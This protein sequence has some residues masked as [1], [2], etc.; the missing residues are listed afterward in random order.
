MAGGLPSLVSAL[1]LT[2]PGDLSPAPSRPCPIPVP[3]RRCPVSALALPL[4]PRLLLF[5][6]ADQ[7][8]LGHMPLGVRGH[9]PPSSFSEARRKPCLNPRDTVLPLISG[10]AGASAARGQAGLS[11]HQGVMLDSGLVAS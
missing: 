1:K 10:K 9:V 8:Q 11:R 7:Q 5:F 2:L 4:S 6:K 3:S